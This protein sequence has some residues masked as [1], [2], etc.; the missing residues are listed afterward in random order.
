[1]AKWDSI[2]G[3]CRQELV[4]IGQGLDTQALQ[5]ALDN[6]LLSAQEIAAGPSAWQ[7]LPGATTFDS[8]ALS[9]PTPS[10]QADPI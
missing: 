10:L 7:A 2:V 6:C 9:A 5:R 1:M 8:L 3:D 4:F